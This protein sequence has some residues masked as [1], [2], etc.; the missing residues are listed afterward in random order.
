MRHFLGILDP[1]FP[2]DVST[3]L[4]LIETCRVSS[5]ASLKFFNCGGRSVVY[6]IL[7]AQDFP[8]DAADDCCVAGAHDGGT[9][10]VG[11][12]AGVY[13]LFAGFMGKAA[14]RAAGLSGGEVGVEVGAGGKFREMGWGKGEGGGGDGRRGLDGHEWMGDQDFSGRMRVMNRYSSTTWNIMKIRRE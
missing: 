12:G 11:Q 4:Q 2:L 9:V 5:V 8:A 6:H 14:R 10:A 1:G 7:G 13:A 3:L